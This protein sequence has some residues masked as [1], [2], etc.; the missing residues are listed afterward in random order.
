MRTWT[1]TTT[2]AARPQDVL[3]VLTDPDAAA[4]WAPVPFDVDELQGRRLAT[5]TRARVSGKGHLGQRR[6]EHADGVKR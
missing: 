3:A 6:S 1:A 4:E 5:G 2:T